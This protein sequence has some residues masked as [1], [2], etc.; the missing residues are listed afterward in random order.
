M[1]EEL[2]WE[3]QIKK[4]VLEYIEAFVPV[5]VDCNVGT[6]YKRKVVTQFEGSAEHDPYVAEGVELRLKFKFEQP[7]DLRSIEEA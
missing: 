3:D 2:T 6:F 7:I 1:G 5:S 4:T